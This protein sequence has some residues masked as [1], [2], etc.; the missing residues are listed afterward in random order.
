[1]VFR[2]HIADLDRLA[3]ELQGFDVVS[4]MRERTPFPATLLERLGDLR[5]LIT[6][7]ARN[8]S[9]DLAAATTHGIVVS[10]TGQLDYPAAELAW[11]LLLAVARNVPG[12]DQALRE[13]RWQTRLGV[14]LHGKRIGIVGLGR[15]GS[16][17]AGYAKAFG[18]EPVAWSQNLTAQ[19]AQEVGV[20]LVSKEELLRTSDFVTV[21]LKLSDRTRGLLGRDELALLKPTA[22]LIN[23]SRGPIVDEAALLE[24]LRERRIAGAALDVF[25]VEPL[26]TDHP[27]LTL[28]NVVITPHLGYVS[29]ESF[30]LFYQET[31]EAIRA[32]RAGE[33]RLVL[34]PEVL[35]AAPADATTGRTD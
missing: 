29:R 1:M 9:I 12:E 15:L 19:R 30:A 32:F 28:D 25:D 27:L 20:A 13:G 10:G 26:P 21:H 4:I 22:Y 17:I 11:T 8:D 3:G 6:T 33:P 24:V 23:T 35:D 7:G 34:N 18:M 5:L 31:V 14:T 16:R 2:E